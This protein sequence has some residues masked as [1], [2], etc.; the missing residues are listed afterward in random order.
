MRRALALLLLLATAA[1]L[2][3]GCGLK[4]ALE[5]NAPPETT[6][7]VQGALDTVNHVVR[8]HWLGTDVDGEVVGY[9]IRFRSPA[10]PAETAWVFTDRTDSTFTVFTPAGYANPVFEV[11]AID[12]DGERD[13]TPARND[14]QFSNQAPIVDIVAGPA[15][16]DTTFASVTVTWS[17]GDPDGDATRLQFLVWLD[18]NEANPV[19]TT[20]RTFTVPTS[21]FL[22]AGDLVTG[23]RTLYVR[24]V[25]DGGRAG[26]A[27]S[28]TWIVRRAVTGS[29]A[30]LLIVDDVPTSNPS[31]VRFDT[32]FTNSAA[33]A[34]IAA[35]EYTVLR[36]Q[37]GQPFRSA[38]DVAQT[39]KLFQSVIWYRSNETVFPLLLHD[40]QQG[41]E[42]YVDAGGRFYI[43]GLY[44]V[45]GLNAAG[46]FTPDFVTRVLDCDGLLTSFVNTTTFS[47]SSNGLGN[48]NNSRFRSSSLQDS[49]RQNQL[50]VRTGEAGGLRAFRVRSNDQA[51]LW[52]LP[53]QLVPANADSVPVAVNTARP[54]GGRIIVNTVPFSTGA[55]TG[56]TGARVI[57]KL[58]QL[59]LAGAP[60]PAL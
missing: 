20:S 55:G 39:L 19:T 57:P 3:V 35:D 36:M 44:L 14:F 28:V 53:A 5:P 46:A 50:Q 26:E 34:G 52:A 60:R 43:E 23:R 17:A 29:L 45:E 47:D 9:E 13:P 59:L 7:Y 51:L 31:N 58:M 10:A 11:R 2:L 37:T 25:D 54:G 56:N 15:V 40:Y 8:L 38:A 4:G 24:A 18:G 48:P 41:I 49:T 6:Q 42:D 27:D 33:R 32:M 30:R 22:V 16:N 12:D 21:S 1:L